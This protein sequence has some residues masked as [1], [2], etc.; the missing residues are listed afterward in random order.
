[1][2]VQ[3]CLVFL[4]TDFQNNRNCVLVDK[5]QRFLP[6]RHISN[7]KSVEETISDLTEECSYLHPKWIL[8]HCKIFDAR[9][10]GNTFYVFLSMVIPFSTKLKDPYHWVGH[11][12][13]GQYDELVQK[14][15]YKASKL[16]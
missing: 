5:S 16:I 1:M 11:F 4:S 3:I 14:V 10:Q 15:V 7:N 9:K 6:T 8:E 12:D 13:L 2:D